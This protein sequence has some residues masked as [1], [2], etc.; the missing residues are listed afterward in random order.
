M[1]NLPGRARYDYTGGMVKFGTGRDYFPC[2][3]S[4]LRRFA[5]VNFGDDFLK[6]ARAGS[7]ES[8]SK[9]KNRFKIIE[10]SDYYLYSYFPQ[11]VY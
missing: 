8:I 3:I 11:I 10:V 6:Q 9:I 4:H 5:K 1:K 7:H 2:K